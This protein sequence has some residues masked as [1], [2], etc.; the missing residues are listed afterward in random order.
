MS[1][2]RANIKVIYDNY[3]LIVTSVIWRGDIGTSSRVLE[4]DFVNTKDGRSRMINIQKGRPIF[5]YNDGVEL[6]RGVVFR[7]E[8]DHKGFHTI[9]AYDETVYLN[10]NF[11]TRQFKNAKASDIISRL[12]RDFGVSA[13]N[14][15]DTEYVISNVVFHNKSLWQIMITVLSMT[16][17]QTG[18]K[19]HLFSKGGKIN[20]VERKSQVSKWVIS[21]DVNITSASYAQSIEDTKTQIKVKGSSAEVTLKNNELSKQFGVLQEIEEMD[22]K[23]KRSQLEQRAKQLLKERSVI[24]DT[25]YVECLGIDDVIAGSAV[26]MN[27]PMTGIIGAYYVI[28]DSHTFSGGV[29][30]M[31]LELSAT[32]ELPAMEYEK[33]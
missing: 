27:E 14:I 10:K 20:V 5:L 12:C 3:E 33:E 18:K 21:S 25:A 9:T 28:S 1:P 13:G 22:G 31:S 4:I 2:G 23:V 16:T 7:D 11:D 29:H 26:Y 8:I 15:V 6:F 24:D 30:T 32:D 17:M 19:F